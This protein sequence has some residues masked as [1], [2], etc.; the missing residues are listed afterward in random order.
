MR[1]C[2][3]C[4]ALVR[5]RSRVVPGDGA[6]P[7]VVAF[8]GIAPG[9]FGGDRTGV[10]FSGDRSGHIL[11]RMIEAAGFGPVFITNLVRCNPRDERGRNRDPSR[12][13]I[14]NCRPY[15]DA[16]LGLV[17]PTLVACLGRIAWRAMA[18]KSAAFE[19]GRGSLVAVDGYL[20]YAMYHPGYLVRGAYS[21]RQYLRD[22]ARLADFVNRLRRATPVDELVAPGQAG[23][24]MLCEENAGLNETR[25]G[26]F[27]HT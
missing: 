1:A 16:E 9:R 17:R 22:F 25:T 19:P 15:L 27:R 26:D 4:A 2:S 11:R 12:S 20:L 5:C 13:E 18:G 14:A 6:A 8:V 24:A 21:E 23:A 10:P 3:R 7:A